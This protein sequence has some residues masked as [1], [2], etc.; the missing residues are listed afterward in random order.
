M[1]QAI[2]RGPADP[3]YDLKK[4]ADGDTTAD[5]VDLGVGIYR[6]EQGVYQQLK[7]V[8]EVQP[9]NPIRCDSLHGY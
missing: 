2:K 5:K 9:T 1:F 8:K 7:C 3:M 4:K 6:S